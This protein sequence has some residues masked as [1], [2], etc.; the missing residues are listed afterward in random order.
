LNNLDPTTPDDFDNNYFTNLQNNRGLLQT[1]QILFSTSGADTVAVV[2]R[3]A[4]SQTAFFD[5]FAQSMI[6]L[7]NLSPLTGSNGEIRADCKRV[8]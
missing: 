2:N 6:K 5:S 4:N 7:G 3:F 1:D 8:N